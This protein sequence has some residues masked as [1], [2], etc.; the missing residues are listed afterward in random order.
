[1]GYSYTIY[2]KYFQ[3]GKGKV[4]HAHLTC[5]VFLATIWFFWKIWNGSICS[6]VKSKRSVAIQ[7]FFTYGIAY[8]SKGLLC[9]I[10]VWNAKQHLFHI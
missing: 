9:L 1:M 10:K 8:K 6:A 7:Y 3:Q 5:E 4:R 2:G